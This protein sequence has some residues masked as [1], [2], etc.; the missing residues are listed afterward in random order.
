MSS[1]S[2]RN[3]SKTREASPRT[4]LA[5]VGAHKQSMKEINEAN[6]RLA[7]RLQEEAAEE[8]AEGMGRGWSRSR[9]R[10]RESSLLEGRPCEE[11]VGVVPFILL[12]W[13]EGGM[14]LPVSVS[15]EV[16]Q[17]FVRQHEHVTFSLSL[18]LTPAHDI[19]FPGSN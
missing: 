13:A 14:S 11:E 10:S 2:K 12:R 18:S 8:G 9:N 6:W 1:W 7:K 4:D 17:R 15:E 16:L 19:S 5:D 3:T